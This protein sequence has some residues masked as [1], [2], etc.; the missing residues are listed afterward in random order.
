MISENVLKELESIVNPKNI[1]TLYRDRLMYSKDTW[2]LPVIKFKDFESLP[3]PDVIVWPENSEQVSAV[4]KFANKYKIPVTPFGGGAAVTGAP[5]A[6]K[7]GII[8]DIKKMNKILEINRTSLTAR[9]QPGIIGEN[10]ERR[11]NRY[12]LTLCHY[13]MSI[14]TSTL[15]GFLATRA[16][17][18]LSTKYGNIDDMIMGIK[19]VLPT[20]ELIETKAVPKTS[21]GP[22]IMRLFFGSEGLL[23]VITEL[24]LKLRKVPEVQ[25]FRVFIFD[26]ME[27][28][29]D[30]IREF[31]QEDITP[32]IV[33]LYDKQDTAITL[34]NIGVSEKGNLLILRFDGLKELVDLQ[35]KLVT[36]ICERHH[37]KML[38]SWIGEHWWNNR[39]DQYYRLPDILDEG[40]ADTIEIAVTWDKLLDLYYDVVNSMEEAEVLVM[41]HISHVYPWGAAI[42]FTFAGDLEEGNDK[43]VHLREAWNA[44]MTAVM[45]H[46]GT[47]SHH[48]GVGIARNPWIKEELGSAFELIKKLKR[49]LD[50]NNIL[51]PGKM[52]LDGVDWP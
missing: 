15:G 33:R 52:G 38:D 22:D 3:L 35:D 42:Y 40:F 1:S 23:G 8:L 45:R 11:L 36:K 30:A 39:L 25:R 4:L 18:I 31:M 20:G 47:I 44:A 49:A 13:P 34:G 43:Y 28:A 19:V 29:V 37:G 41:A 2:I 5:M 7:G 32:A 24:T 46:G 14:T 48:H 9:V 27:H 12:G 21:T 6:V 17:G 26:S 50:P 51:N 10:L 16:S